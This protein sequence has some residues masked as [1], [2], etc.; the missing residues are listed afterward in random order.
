M[1]T[2][3]A[4]I[5]DLD[6]TL[7]DTLEDLADAMNRVLRRDDLPTHDYSAY[8][9][10]IGRG[11][12]NLVTRALP[13]D[14]R[15]DETI[16][17]CLSRLLADYARHCLDKTRLYEGVADL[18]GEL[19]GAGVSLAVHSNKAEAL[20]RRI[21]HGLTESGTFAVVKG[22]QPGVPSPSA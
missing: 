11:M 3:E 9:G 5:F 22:A 13:V 21:V 20:A 17:R 4:V 19:H 6:G 8:R 1:A 10:L 18:L 16:D 12:A 7:A 2:F 15:T 14:R